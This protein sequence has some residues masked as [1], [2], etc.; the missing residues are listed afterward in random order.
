M[1]INNALKV[2]LSFYQCKN[3]AMVV[4][5]EPGLDIDNLFR[6]FCLIALPLNGDTMPARPERIPV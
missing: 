4:V 1:K 5:F 2:R 3:Q 6:L